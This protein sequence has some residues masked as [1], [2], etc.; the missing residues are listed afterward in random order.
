LLA[1]HEIGGS[2]GLDEELTMIVKDVGL[3]EHAIVAILSLVVLKE[4][5]IFI[6]LGNTILKA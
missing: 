2:G 1:D 6:K 5:L 4:C 3:V